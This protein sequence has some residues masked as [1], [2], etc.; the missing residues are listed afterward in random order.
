[1]KKTNFNLIK[2]LTPTQKRIALIIG[3]CVLCLLLMVGIWW[4]FGRSKTVFTPSDYEWGK[5]EAEEKLTVEEDNIGKTKYESPISIYETIT[6]IE[7][8]GEE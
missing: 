8:E 3:C 5:I 1:M 4:F 7:L 6:D 2:N